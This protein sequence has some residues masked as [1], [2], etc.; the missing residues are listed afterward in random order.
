MKVFKKLA[1]AGAA[2]MMAVT[3]M[4]VNAS[5]YNDTLN[6]H[7]VSVGSVPN[8]W[9]D[10]ESY[11]PSTTK[12]TITMTSCQ[13]ASIN[14]RVRIRNTLANVDTYSQ[15]GYSN[16]VYLTSSQMGHLTSISLEFIDLGSGYYSSSV[17]FKG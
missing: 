13:L 7:Y 6:I 17:N 4:A 14:T 9:S 12:Q 8:K 2:I 16:T 1:A 15:G 10:S 5:A 3:G 11:Y